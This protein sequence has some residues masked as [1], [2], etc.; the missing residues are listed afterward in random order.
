MPYLFGGDCSSCSREYHLR[1]Q[2]LLRMIGMPQS[3]ISIYNCNNGKPSGPYPFIS[4]GVPNI[5]SSDWTESAQKS[6]IRAR[7]SVMRPPEEGLVSYVDI[8]KIAPVIILFSRS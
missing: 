2:S 6:P 7:V 1:F 3:T 5:T 8:H 4:S